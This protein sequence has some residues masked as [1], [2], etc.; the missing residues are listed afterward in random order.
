MRF[1]KHIVMDDVSG[2]ADR[3]NDF[4][5][6]LTVAREFNF[7]CVYVFYTIYPSRCNWQMIISQRKIFNIFF[8]S[9]QTT[10]VAKILSSYCNRYTYKYIPHRDL[11]INRLYYYISNSVE[12]KCLTIETR[13]VNNLESSEFRTGAKNGKEH[14]CYGYRNKKDKVSNK[15]LASRKETSANEI[16]F[17]IEKLIGNPN[18]AEN[19]YYKIDDELKEFDNDRNKFKRLIRGTG[20]SDI[21]G[22]T[23]K[24]KVSKKPRFI[25]G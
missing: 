6:F 10:L 24:R 8:G 3:S 25:S 12:K 13:D 20:T 2:L 5:N 15:F 11:W 22:T 18:N 4:A 7:A 17:S 14:V 23:R 9:L 16:I 1:Y 19:I 21:A